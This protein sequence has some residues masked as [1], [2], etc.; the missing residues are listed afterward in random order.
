MRKLSLLFILLLSISYTQAQEICDNGI[1]DT[2]NGLIDLNDPECDCEGLGLPL[3]IPNIIP[4]PSFEDY[5]S[6]P[7]T[8]SQMSRVDHWKDGTLGDSEYFNCGFSDGAVSAANIFAPDGNAFVG[9]RFKVQ[10]KEYLSV[11]LNSP[12]LAGETY[13][14][15][16]YI[17]SISLAT[18][19]P[20]WPT[21]SY[22]Y[23]AIDITV[24][25]SNSCS[26]QPLQ[27]N[28]LCPSGASS[29]WN[30]IG[31]KNYSP[32]ANWEIMTIEITPSTDIN[33]IMIGSP[34]YLPP[35]Y[36]FMQCLDP[37]FLFDN[38]ILAE[39]D[40]FNSLEISELGYIC[41]NDL[42]LNATSDSLG[43]DWQWYYEG[44]AIVGETNSSFDYSA[45]SLG[46]GRY[47]VLYT[48]G[49]NCEIENIKIEL[50]EMPGADFSLTDVCQGVDLQ[51]LDSTLI[52]TSGGVFIDSWEWDFGNGN[53]S[54]N[55]N[56]TVSF[57]TPGNYSIQLNA[58]GNNMCED[59]ITKMITIHPKPTADFDF[60][61]VCNETPS[62]FVNLSLENGGT[63]IDNLN[64][65]FGDGNFSNL[66][67]PTHTYLN[68]SIYSV[69]LIAESAFGCKDTVIK[70]V[71]VWPNPEVDFSATHVCLENATDFTDLTTISNTVPNNSLLDWEWNFGDGSTS[72]L[73]NPI[74]E[75]SNDGTFNTVL[76]VTS[77]RGCKNQMSKAVIVHPLPEVSFV[78][79]G[80]EGCSPVCPD[81]NST[82]TINSPSNITNLEWTLSDGSS[83]NGSIL[84]ECFESSIDDSRYLDLTL[85]ATS[86]EGCIAEHTED[87]YIAVHHNP[88][89]DFYY[90]PEEPS[91][92]EEE[93]DFYNTSSYANSYE[94]T[95]GN[96]G[97]SNLM[98]PSIVFPYAHDHHKVMLIAKTTENCADTLT[99]IIEITDKIIF[100]I[101]NAFT[102]DNNNVNQNFQP[103]FT[104]GFEP[105]NFVLTIY[106]RWGELIFKSHDASK[107]WDG[108][109][110]MKSGETVQSGTYIW[111]IVFEETMSSKMHVH[112][113]QVTL[114]K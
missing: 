42:V 50:P 16:F 62:N 64:W 105:Q 11:C 1:D 21:C 15:V 25:G 101:P 9:S 54:T 55:Q 86:N 72:N 57:P 23:G 4:N 70:D 110:G 75:Y 39:K 13:Q 24:Y 90:S 107:G 44:V 53:F 31:A 46:T 36:H 18:P 17:A 26:T 85:K 3:N 48:I 78:G 19:P 108:T 63:V 91:V 10:W 93:V 74:H 28:Q 35:E 94:W 102:P 58:K 76:E 106:N 41:S 43:G 99:K 47:S 32:D 40:S 69:Q 98:N 33:E 65:N 66:E 112:Q 7:T 73:Q 97:S 49:G 56:P 80:I 52:N 111:K 12:M 77:N 27:T 114:L 37:Y 29:A 109:Y 22:S 89:A 20:N 38:F 68:D 83:F 2:G 71:I 59:S 81:I 14:L 67:N 100:Y 51:F 8:F 79:F 84:S 92:I 45:H 61:T 95:F 30:I 60:D 88:I 104:S 87:S 113:G 96:L 82:S 6:C 34:C 103:V 5:S